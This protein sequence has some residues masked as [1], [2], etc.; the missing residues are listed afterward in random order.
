MTFGERCTFIR[1]KKK[2]SQADMGKALSIG[3]DAYGRYERGE[4]KPSIQVA[5]KVANILNVSLDYLAGKSDLELDEKM[6]KR[7]EL[8]SKLPEDQKE[9]I[10]VVLDAF[11]DR[12]KIQGFV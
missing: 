9:H 10:L 8:V 1:K 6:I 5:I 3:G 7:I 2:M 4:V 11:I 12:M